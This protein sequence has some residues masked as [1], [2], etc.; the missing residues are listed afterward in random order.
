[1]LTTA[2]QRFVRLAEASRTGTAVFGSASR[3]FALGAQF[4]ILL[5]F[6]R[7]F[8]KA[9]FGN[10]MVAFAGYRVLGFGVGTG[11]ASVLLYHISRSDDVA[12]HVRLHRSALIVGAATALVFCVISWI[13]AANVALVFQKPEL[14]GWLKAMT[15]FLFFMLVST[16][17]TGSFEGQS[18]VATAIFLAEVA[19]NFLRLVLLGILPLL[20]F[21]GLWVAHVMAIS[22]ALPWLVSI[23]NL[24]RRDIVGIRWF[25]RWDYGYAIKLTLYN[26]AAMQVQG[27]DMII[28]GWLF[29]AEA[30]ADYAIASRLAALFPFFLQ[31]RVR[32]FG[33]VAGR[34]LAEKNAEAL[35]IEVSTV[36]RFAV[37]LST[38]S[39]GALLLLSPIF[40]QLFWKSEGLAVLLVLLA[41]PPV[42]RALF[43]AGDR[44]LQVAGHASWNMWIMSAALSIVVGIPFLIG[45]SVGIVSLPIAM[46]ISG[47]L[48]NPVIAYGVWRTTSIKL[49]EKR[50]FLIFAAATLSVVLP[51]M[52]VKAGLSM[53]LSGLMFLSLGIALL[54][55]Q[56]RQ[57]KVTT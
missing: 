17:T 54:W 39:V 28:A 56:R 57:A 25:T 41:F 10:F 11:L 24:A 35:A 4:V 44:L 2:R 51:L 55:L 8:D 31:L 27:I 15:P 47:L 37:I 46:I 16:V 52:L 42:Y 53:F 49:I 26:F 30:I 12:E 36:K 1:M 5:I 32:M 22:L 23:R 40:L 50:D 9:D 3:I 21:A 29:P 34:L 48:L 20:G 33:P 18:K 14:E 38:T 45:S 7:L 19:P 43:A 6:S 13:Y